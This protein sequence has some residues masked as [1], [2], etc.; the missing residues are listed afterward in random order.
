MDIDNVIYETIKIIDLFINQDDTL[1][2][3]SFYDENL[4][5]LGINFDNIF[6]FFKKFSNKDKILEYIKNKKYNDIKNHLIYLQTI[7]F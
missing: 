3:Q 4:F 7:Y 1:K 2:N 6:R 5:K